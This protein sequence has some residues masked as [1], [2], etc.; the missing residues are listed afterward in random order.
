MLPAS[1]HDPSIP[2]LSRRNVL[3][4]RVADT[5]IRQPHDWVPIGEHVRRV[6]MV[7]GAAH[8]CRRLSYQSGGTRPKRFDGGSWDVWTL[9]A[10][11][12][13]EAVPLPHRRPCAARSRGP[14]AS[15]AAV[16]LPFCPKP[17]SSPTHPRPSRSVRGSARANALEVDSCCLLWWRTKPN[18][19]VSLT[20]GL[21][22]DNSEYYPPLS[23]PDWP[24][25]ARSSRAGAGERSAC[26]TECRRRFL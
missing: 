22:G 4:G 26:M 3:R 12:Y 10:P 5:C 17:G 13:R 14:P 23:F 11:A 21:Q 25:I 1:S 18:G 6:A 9:L 19:F 24:N 15:R 20:A 8:H 2:A 7:E 16:P